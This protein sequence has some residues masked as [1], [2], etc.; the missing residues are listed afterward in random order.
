MKKAPSLGTVSIKDHATMSQIASARLLG[1]LIG[2]SILIAPLVCGCASEP[3]VRPQPDSSNVVQRPVY[4]VPD[5]KPLYLGGYAG[6][7][8]EP[9]AR[10]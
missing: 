6:A 2:C 9:S 10:P 7:N 4:L 3:S 5:T 8:Y 1:R